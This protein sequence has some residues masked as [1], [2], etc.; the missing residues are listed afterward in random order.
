ME[1]TFLGYGMFYLV[2][3]NL[4]PVAKEIEGALHYTHSTIGD[5]LAFQWYTLL[6]LKVTGVNSSGKGSSK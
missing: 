6:L 2:R 5:I 3:N 1:S 4:S